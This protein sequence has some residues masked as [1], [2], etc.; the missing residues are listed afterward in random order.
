MLT[1]VHASDSN[2][3]RLQ[4]T[5]TSLLHRTW[6]CPTNASLT[7]ELQMEGNAKRLFNTLPMFVRRSCP[8]GKCATSTGASSSIIPPSVTVSC[9]SYDATTLAFPTLPLKRILHNSSV[10]IEYTIAGGIDGDKE[11]GLHHPVIQLANL[12][13]WEPLNVDQI[14]ADSKGNKTATSTAN[15]TATF[16][17]PSTTNAASL[18]S[19]PSP[20]ASATSS[21]KTAPRASHP[22][23]AP[24]TSRSTSA[25]NTALAPTMRLTL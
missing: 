8:T 5:L 6:M 25:T 23:D 19:A 13:N 21:N 20:S 14:V 18:P 15:Q 16:T 12:N 10:S 3:Y 11:D 7:C 24:Y 4:Q 22:A 17:P 9:P 2:S 1:Y